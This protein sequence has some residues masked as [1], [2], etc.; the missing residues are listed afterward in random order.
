[1]SK[2]TLNDTLPPN[3]SGITRIEQARLLGAAPYEFAQRQ[4]RKGHIGISMPDKFQEQA[5]SFFKE[6]D[7]TDFI[8]GLTAFMEGFMQTGPVSE[9]SVGVLQAHLLS[10]AKLIL[11][12]QQDWLGSSQRL[13][14]PFVCA[15]TSEPD[16]QRVKYIQ[17]YLIE[18]D[19]RVLGIAIINAPVFF[20]IIHELT[21]ANIDVF[22]FD[23]D[24]DHR[25]KF[26]DALVRA[27]VE[28]TQQSQQTIENYPWLEPLQMKE[29]WRKTLGL[30]NM[31][32][33]PLMRAPIR[34]LSVSGSRLAHQGVLTFEDMKYTHPDVLKIMDAQA[35]APSHVLVLRGEKQEHYETM[36]SLARR[37]MLDRLDEQTHPIQRASKPRNLKM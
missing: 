28:G 3:D 20:G 17:S 18:L 25:D 9:H 24:K 4:R 27:L 21:Q 23:T 33:P 12:R 8:Q 5:C 26:R 13:W 37:E 6:I 31:E 11:E 32:H 34:D 14:A 36:K 2:F 10:V 19:V 15:G 22:A 35:G 29:V 16:P 30:W 1:M 7:K